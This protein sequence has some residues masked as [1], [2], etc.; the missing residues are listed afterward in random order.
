LQYNKVLY[1]QDGTKMQFVYGAQG[2]KKRDDE[3]GIEGKQSFFLDFLFLFDQ[4][5]RKSF[6]SISDTVYHELMIFFN[7]EA[8]GKREIRREKK[9]FIS[10]NKLAV[11]QSTLHPRRH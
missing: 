3:F 4:A 2:L 11:Q 1:T 10:I 7:T 6:F 5:K 8:R 9:K